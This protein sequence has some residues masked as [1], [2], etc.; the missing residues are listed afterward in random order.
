MEPINPSTFIADLRSRGHDGEAEAA[1]IMNALGQL[2]VPPPMQ[3]AAL[4]SE[5]ETLASRGKS[6]SAETPSASSAHGAAAETDDALGHEHS[7][8]PGSPNSGHPDGTAHAASAAGSE[9]TEH[10]GEPGHVG[11]GGAQ[12]D[13][14]LHDRHGDQAGIDPADPLAGL[15]SDRLRASLAR[16][17]FRAADTVAQ[18]TAIAERALSPAAQ[19]LLQR[20]E[21]IGHEPLPL[22][23]S[24][25]AQAA[26]IAA[27]HG[28]IP[29]WARG[30][31]ELDPALHKSAEQL[32]VRT[33][34]R[35]LAEARSQV[36]DAATSRVRDSGMER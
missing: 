3:A 31:A 15:H 5:P 10:G 12:L 25:E 16:E 23:I 30:N 1:E 9:A 13:P 35:S 24:R 2:P 4:P 20:A 14:T 6:R 17:A 22:D 19:S 26:R 18:D 36:P 8:A 33:P 29:S 21:R 32:P 11:V 7:P 27:L 28:E 34:D